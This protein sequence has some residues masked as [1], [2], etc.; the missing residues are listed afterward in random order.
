MTRNNADFHGY[1]FE[2]EPAH[3]SPLQ[4]YDMH[5]VDAFKDDE[6]VGQ[7]LWRDS[8]GAI[9]VM[10]HPEHRRK[11]VASGLY[12]YGVEQANA[13]GITPPNLFRSSYGM[14]GFKWAQSLGLPENY[15]DYGPEI[16]K[17]GRPS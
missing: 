7:L 4:D 15:G 11:G 17:Y 12:R 14:A 10:V 8:T 16:G 1:R 3:E 2:F 9:D 5:R 6:H 13:A